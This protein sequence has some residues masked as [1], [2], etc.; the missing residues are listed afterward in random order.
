M[1]EDDNAYYVRVAERLR[2]KE[3][4]V[5][6]WDYERLILQHFPC[7]HKVKCIN[8]AT[9]KSFY[10]PGNFLIVVVPD[11]TNRNA[12][13]PL[14]PKVDKNTLDEIAAFLTRHSS[15]WTE[16]QV[17]NPLYEPVQT[18]IR[19][20][21][22]RGFE[23]NYYEKVMDQKI[24]EFLSPWIS[25]GSREIHFGGK[26]TKSMVIKFLEELPFVDYLTAFSLFQY[27]S[28]KQAY[29]G[30]IEV[31]E[32]SNPASILVSAPYHEIINE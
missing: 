5:A 27:S 31:A 26:V 22:K 9:T 3:R 4:T 12:V 28:Q 2:H 21:L 6:I 17:I 30:D 11:L 14:Q 8:H 18:S 16:F 23:F 20:K 13:D 25:S 19:L 29:G 15:A 7:I 24:R 32:A 1:L 10:S